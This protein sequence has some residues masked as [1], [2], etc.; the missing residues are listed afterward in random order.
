VTQLWGSPPPDRRG[1]RGRAPQQSPYGQGPYA[2]NPYGANPY[3]Q[4]PYSQN[5][6]GWG[7]AG[8]QRGFGQSSFGGQQPGVPQYGP[9]P[10]MPAPRRR[11]PFR[12][13]LLAGIALGLVLMASTAVSNMTST[14]SDA[15]YQN[16]QYQVPPPDTTPP[17]LPQPETYEEAETLLTQNPFY[18]QAAPVP[19]RCTSQPINVRTASNAQ[20]ESHF[21]GLMECLLRVWQPPVEAA[22]F[23]LVRPTVTIYGSSITTK[24]GKADVNA[25]YCGADQQVYY[26]N[27]LDEGVPIVARDKWAADVV[28]AHEFGHA[29]Q[30]RTAILIS[31]SALG[32]QANDESTQLSFSRRLETQ[33]DCFSGM[34]IRSVSESLG[35]QESDQQGILEVYDAVGDDTLSRDP[36]IVGNHG[37]GRS[38]QYW[39]NVGLGT[40]DVGACNTYTANSSLVR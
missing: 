11:H 1:R 35:V 3:G 34:F 14:P 16:D 19:V 2:Q 7:P 9:R 8:V 30:A 22:Q 12:A 26:S 6:Y 36:N 23:Q 28:M 5:P 33:A 18:Q 25:F 21:T 39:G 31:S 29:L 10:G 13:L 38:R 15:A 4:N 32:Q 37:R 17:P 27:Q 24:C 20:L 40:S